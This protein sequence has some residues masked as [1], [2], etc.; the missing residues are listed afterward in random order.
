MGLCFAPQIE[1]VL[2][3]GSLS[4]ALATGPGEFKGCL[5]SLFWWQLCACRY[6]YNTYACTFACIYICINTFMHDRGLFGWF[7]SVLPFLDQWICVAGQLCVERDN[8]HFSFPVQGS[9]YFNGPK[10]L[11]FMSATNIMCSTFTLFFL[12]AHCFTSSV[13]WED[14]GCFL[15]PQMWGDVR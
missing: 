15:F 2:S 10:P 13:N 12:F 6:A 4:Y 1:C 11:T 5:L 8:T 7:R 9:L 3:F 14:W